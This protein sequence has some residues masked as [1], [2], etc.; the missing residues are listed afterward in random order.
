MIMLLMMIIISSLLKLSNS[1][2]GWLLGR[3]F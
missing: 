1:R 3:R 2:P